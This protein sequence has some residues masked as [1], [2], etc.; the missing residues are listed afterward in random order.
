MRALA[1]LAAAAV[2]A[3]CGSERGAITAGG[4]VVGDNLT[5]Y[6]SVPEPGARRRARHGRRLEAGDRRG[7]RQGRRLRDQL[8]R[9]ST[10]ARSARPIRAACRPPPPSRSIRDAQVIAVVGAVRSDAALTSLPL[11]NAAGVLLVSPGAGY[12]GFT[13][14]GRPRRARALVPVRPPDLRARDRGRRRAGAGA[15][16]RRQRRPRGDRGR[17]R[18]GRGRAGRGAARRGRPAARAGRPA[19]RRRRS[20]RAA[21]CA[22][23]VASPSRSRARRRGRRSC[24]ATS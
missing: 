20:T 24:S 22:R 17:G 19:R 10:R 23:R 1:A 7:G 14:A 3:G 12:P 6:A 5:I 9:R 15:A 18:Q 8:R 11:F 4:R 2:L 21:T 16:A 13:A